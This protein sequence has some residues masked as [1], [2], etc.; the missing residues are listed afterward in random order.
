[1]MYS[2]MDG[3]VW[4]WATGGGKKGAEFGETSLP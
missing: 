4:M 1:M 3:E 2:R